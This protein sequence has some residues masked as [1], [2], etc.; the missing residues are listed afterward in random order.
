MELDLKNNIVN[1]NKKI[2][3][4]FIKELQDY[5][6]NNN[7]LINVKN[8]EISLINTNHEENKIITK[9]RDKMF[10]ERSK[11]L[12][13]Y[14]QKTLNNGEMYYIYSKN[15]K[16]ENSYNLCICK[17]GKSH[18]I[19]ETSR[20]ALPSGAK[21]GCV[22][23]MLGNNYIL[24]E[25]STREIKKELNKMKT[26]ILEEQKNFLESQRI[27]GHIYEI[28]EKEEDRVWLFDITNRSNEAFEEIF[29]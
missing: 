4:N 16:K 26:K 25:A 6:E 12:N 2:V 22:L 21:I 24:D 13:N 11:I 1:K 5:L 10:V 17:E 19:M 15:S 20:E 8:E 9:F 14:A 28:A 18:I 3:Q 23:R 29:E 7:S 27:E